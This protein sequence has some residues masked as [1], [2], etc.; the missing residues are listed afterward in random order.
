MEKGAEQVAAWRAAD[1][2]YR[3][4]CRSDAAAPSTENANL[5]RRHQESRQRSVTNWRWSMLVSTQRQTY[6][7]HAAILEMSSRSSP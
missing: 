7:H 2:E 1:Q 6:N 4:C 3:R 5:K